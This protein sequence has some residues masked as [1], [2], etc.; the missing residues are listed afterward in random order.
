MSEVK[1][2]CN[3]DYF[4]CGFDDCITDKMTLS[5]RVEQLERDNNYMNSGNITPVRNNR[6]ARRR[7]MRK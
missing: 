2:K 6:K 5:E 3:H 1:A 7:H 4:H